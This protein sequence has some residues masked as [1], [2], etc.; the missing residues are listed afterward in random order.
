MALRVLFS[1]TIEGLIIQKPGVCQIIIDMPYF[2]AQKSTNPNVDI[3]SNNHD[4]DLFI[5]YAKKSV[6]LHHKYGSATIVN[7]TDG[8][9]DLLRTYASWIRNPDD[10]DDK[11][12]Y[13]QN[14][15]WLEDRYVGG[16]KK[17]RKRR[18]TRR[19]R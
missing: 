3:L 10:F 1:E 7:L 4:V 16:S 19:R 6:E 12:Y 18:Q 2:N 8:E 15:S 11:F 5:N 9:L 13:R 17:S 14:F